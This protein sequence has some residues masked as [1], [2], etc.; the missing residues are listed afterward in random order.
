MRCGRFWIVYLLVF[1]CAF[2]ARGQQ[3]D[4]AGPKVDVHVKRGDVTLPID[5]VP[6]LLPGD[7][8]WIH[9]DLPASQSEHF[10]LIVAFLRGA[11]NP[12]PPE[13][14]TRIEAWSRE[15]REEGMFVTVP[16]EAEQAIVFLAPATGGDFSTLR[17][18]VRG[19]PGMFVR[20]TQDLQA[21]SWDRLR[22]DAYLDEVKV[23][24]QT[25]PKSLR[26][27]AEKTARSL[28]IKVNLQCFE[29][30]MEQQAACLSQHTEGLV[31][32]DTNT[33]SRVEQL[34]SASTVD[35][36]N[37]I[38]YSHVGGAGAYS[39]YI[40]AILDT[41]KILSSLHT[42]R[43][44]YIPALALPR[45]DTLN[46]RLS[47]PPSFRNP[48]SV[49][50]IALPPVGKAVMP[51][52]HPVNTSEQFCAQQPGL[53]LPAEGAPLVLATQMAHDLSLQIDTRNGPVQ[54]PLK[55]APAQG[56]LELEHPAPSLPEGN[57]TGTVRGKWGFDNWEG[58]RYHLHSAQPDGWSVVPGDLSALVVG[59]E[60]T[61]HLEGDSTLCVNRIEQQPDHGKP[62]TLSWKSPSPDTLEIRVPMNSVS[63]GPVTLHIWQHGLDKPD[64]LVLMAYTEAA[65]LDHLTLSAGDTEATLTG[66]RLD[67]VAKVSLDGISWTPAGLSRV[68]DSDRLEMTAGES[69]AG[70]DPGR[71]YSARVLLHDGRKLHVPVTVEPPRPQ[72]ALLSKGTQ[73]LAS[74]PPSPV[75]LGSPDDLP[76]DRRFVFFVKSRTPARFPRNQ[77]IELAATDGGFHTM[78]SLTDGTLMLEDATTAMGMVDP[79]ARFGASAFGPLRMRA[80]TAQGITGDWLP[81]GTL[82]RL[83]GFNELRCPRAPSKPCLLS[84]VNLFLA[85]SFASASGFENTTDVPLDFTGTQLSVP[86]PN[87]G[88]LYFKLRDDP[89]TVQTLTMP[90]LPLSPAQVKAAPAPPVAGDA[91]S[92]TPRPAQKL[93]TG[94]TPA[95][96]PATPL[97]D[98][99]TP[100][101]PAAPAAPKAQEQ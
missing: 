93:P 32:D 68:N 45:A 1:F 58:P 83:P 77:K 79:L 16:R 8:L 10:V 42:A 59:R 88:V 52:L 46:L 73:Q 100:A 34:A 76:L 65:A 31:M 21:A 23:T 33:Q 54:I 19:R 75:T 7:R 80:V 15:A 44:Q 64:T 72:V 69:T 3:F 24:S 5:Q 49:V 13:W 78:L 81:L 39:P 48:K 6:N 96:S 2:P 20:A 70:L 40:G 38:S 95:A 61:L 50:V 82:V 84:G 9:P 47:V 29:K 51:P 27:R 89:A 60:D 22:L 12:P 11:T 14:F 99:P 74:K 56:G 36:M 101:T 4:L 17:N 30:P 18:T 71:H 35:L 67:E 41:A 53:I 98:T 26:E 97:S 57:L 91:L 37:Q 94:S 62:I 90:V 43:Y 87:D 66:N 28:G 25:D 55:A 86:H 92:E 85:T 63:P